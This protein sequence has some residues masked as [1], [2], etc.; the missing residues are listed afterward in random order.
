[1]TDHANERSRSAWALEDK[2]WLLDRQAEAEKRGQKRTA[3]DLAAA[4]A[5]HVNS[6]RRDDQVPIKAPGKTSVN[7]WIQNEQSLRKH[8]A[9]SDIHSQRARTS[10]HPRMEEASLQSQMIFCLKNLMKLE[11]S[12]MC[13]RVSSSH[14]ACFLLGVCITVRQKVE[15][16]AAD[17]LEAK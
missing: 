6:K 7:E 12:Q 17:Q 8:A 3:L 10:Q 4:L 1:M 2:I 5:E 14:V 16:D 9:E 13:L 15:R 11:S